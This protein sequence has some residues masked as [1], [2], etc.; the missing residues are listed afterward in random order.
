MA[1][2]QERYSLDD[3]L[4]RLQ[5]R[6]ADEQDP[7]ELVTREDGT[8]AIRV[9]KRKRRS[10]QPGKTARAVSPQSRL[11]QLSATIIVIVVALLV[12][13]AAIIY[14]NSSAYQKNLASKIS[15]AT[16]ARPDLRQFRM[17]PTGANA[18]GL[19]LLWPEGNILQ[20]LKL[21]TLQA[22]AHP[23]SFMG[24]KFTG[25]EVTAHEGQLMLRIPQA[26]ETT[27]TYPAD[28]PLLRDAIAFNRYSIRNLSIQLG[29]VMSPQTPRASH[30]EASFYPRHSSGRPQLT[31]SRG[32]IH[33]PQ[34]PPL[35]LS[36]G[37]IE[38]EGDVVNV[39][40]VL[41]QHESNRHGNFSISGKFSPYGASNQTPL[42]VNLTQ[43][44]IEH[45][46]GPQLGYIISGTVDTPESAKSNY[47]TFV[48]DGEG[49]SS[50]CSISFTNSVDTPLHLKGLPFLVSLRQMIDDPWFEVPAFESQ[51]E[52]E[53]H[54]NN[55]TTRLRDLRF[56]AKGRMQ[57]RGEISV[58]IGGVLSGELLIGLA[59][60]VIGASPNPELLETVFGPENDD[61]RW[62][63][64]RMSGTT[65]APSDDFRKIVDA[66]RA[67][68]SDA[69]ATKPSPQTGEPA[70][71]IPSFEDLTPSR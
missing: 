7:G 47:L 17:N 35:K 55:G 9:R 38:F 54:K 52:G 24:R 4:N 57:I 27:R 58:T 39:V 46:L 25:D 34:F 31:I 22:S 1:S 36:R 23:V 45:L 40:Q 43:F 5:N 21:S 62:L 68:L 13:G 32:D 61:Y 42:A 26:G 41:L 30:V 33:L 19:Q 3:M 12:S 66:A 6:Q 60:P 14:A 65:T 44:Q 64:L 63:K 70:P 69:A 10:S 48:R 15:A 20:S 37:H 71:A 51:A 2:D 49:I 8:Q 59:D 16:G 53:I 18:A 11:L 50:S 28:T 29:S 67:K 56:A